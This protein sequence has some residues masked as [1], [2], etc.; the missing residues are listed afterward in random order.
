MEILL[1]DNNTHLLYYPGGKPIPW[2][3]D[4]NGWVFYNAWED[5]KPKRML[6]HRLVADIM[7]QRD[8]QRHLTARDR[9]IHANGNKLDNREHNLTIINYSQQ[10]QKRR[11]LENKTSKFLGVSFW[12]KRQKWRARVRYREGRRIVNKSLG[13]FDTEIE[14]A[15]AYNQE[16]I[17]H[18]PN[19][20]LNIVRKEQS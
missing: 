2:T 3:V 18:Y 5:K 20:Q 17:L 4:A 6:L 12:G 15:L 10:G 8:K 11:K 16:V 19:P 14:A 9:V 1:D 7:V 13:M